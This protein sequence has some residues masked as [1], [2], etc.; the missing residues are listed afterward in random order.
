M[1]I[2]GT[3][4]IVGIFGYP[5]KHTASPIMHNEAFRVL[6]LKYVYIPFEVKPE[7]I[8]EA[9]QALI[10]LNM[11]GVN[12]TIPHKETVCPHL[13]EMSKE[14]E[15]IGAVNTIVVK[16]DK[17]IGYNTDGHGFIDSLR[18]DGQERVEGKTLLVIGAGGAA[19][20]V[21]TQSALEGAGQI[22]ITDKFEEKA[23]D[24]ADNVNKNISPDKVKVIHPDE[25]TSRIKDADILINATPIGMKNSDPLIVDQKL[26]TPPLLVFDLVYNVGDTRLIK[27][28]EKQGCR[29]VGGVGM[30]AY[31]GARAFKLWT[32]REAPI[33]VMRRILEN[34]FN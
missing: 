32:G 24:L 26:L 6:K 10:P 4:K 7:R 34:M 30:L 20:A 3:T 31:Q 23:K 8:R 9:V 27:I 28:A 19:R 25:V 33:G 14:A 18:E 21:V 13:H 11:T 29:I 1:N 15:L 17:L 12:V 22:L 5:I 16:D 2:E